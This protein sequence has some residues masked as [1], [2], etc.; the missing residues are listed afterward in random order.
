MIERRQSSDEKTLAQAIQSFINSPWAIVSILLLSAALRLFMLGTKNLWHDEAHSLTYGQT[1]IVYQLTHPENAPP[2]YHLFLYFWL[3]LGKSDAFIRLP[4][5]LAGIAS[6]WVTFRIGQRLG[7]R[8]MGLVLGLLT[9]TSPL[10]IHHAQEA[11]YYSLLYFFSALSLYFYLRAKESGDRRAWVG[12]GLSSLLCIYIHYYSFLLILVENLDFLFA[13]RCREFRTRWKTWFLVQVGLALSFLPWVLFF[14]LQIRA[15]TRG[16][17]FYPRPETITMLHTYLDFAAGRVQP[18]PDGVLV[19]LLGLVGVGG[20]WLASRQART[21]SLW[22]LLLIVPVGLAYLVSLR[23]PIYE[24]KHLIASSL[25]CHVLLA[26]AIVFARRWKLSVVILALILGPVIVSLA[27]YYR[28]PPRQNWHQLAQLVEAQHQPGDVILF[29]G[30]IS[31]LT[32]AHYYE[33]DLDLDMYGFQIKTPWRWRVPD[34]AAYRALGELWV[35]YDAIGGYFP[36]QT[37]PITP[38]HWRRRPD[39]IGNDYQRV[40]L[41]FFW[42]RWSLAEHEAQMGIKCHS[43]ID[44]TLDSQDELPLYLCSLEP[45]SRAADKPARGKKVPPPAATAYGWE[46]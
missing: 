39:E 4:S 12:Y 35:N 30:R 18:I 22:L 9:A 19:P 23:V 21:V 11:R 34:K 44:K 32:F 24:T 38:A 27:A 2:L 42:N 14:L 31:Y 10:L 41:I 15:A 5:A 17:T 43:A 6:V 1:D 26:Y 3:A 45:Q 29:D 46:H 25:A 36:K 16:E 33:N 40:W 20:L 8:I 13:M 28:M 37:P 7:G